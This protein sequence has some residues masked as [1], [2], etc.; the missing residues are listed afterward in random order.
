MTR[1][2]L[3]NRARREW[4]GSQT[5]RRQYPTYPHYWRERYARIYGLGARGESGNRA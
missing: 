2:Q 3:E 4:Q 1:P 5:V